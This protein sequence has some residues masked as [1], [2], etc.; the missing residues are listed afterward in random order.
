MTGHPTGQSGWLPARRRLRTSVAGISAA[1]LLLSLAPAADPPGRAATG[2]VIPIRGVIDDIMRDSIQRRV[3]E[4]QAAGATTLIFEID[5]P[6]GMVTSALDICRMIKNLPASV[7]TVAWVH[8]EAYSAGA[9]IAVACHQMWMSPSSS[10]GDCA[11]IM[12]VPVGGVQELGQTE[13]AKAES[14]ILQQFRDSAARN[15]YDQLLSRAMVT[16]GEEVWWLE[17]MSDPADRRFVT[18]EE[19][20]K[21]IDDV[22]EDAREWKLVESY[23][24]PVSGKSIPVVQ[25]VDRANE[26]LTMS[27]YDAVAFGF[28]RGVVADLGELSEKLGLGSIPITFEKSG[29]EKFAMWL[30]SPIVR[31]ILLVIVLIGGYVEFQHPGVI[32]PGVTALIALAIF[33]GAPYA[34]GLAD[35]WTIVI[36]V[37][38]LIL[39]GIEVFVTPGF[40]ILG[41]LGIALI[42]VAIIGSFVP[43]EP[44]APPFSLPSLQATW[45]GLVTG[46]KVLIG[47][48]VVSLVGVVLLAR[49]LPESRMATG[50]V[51]ANP[52]ADSL[53]LSEPHPEVAQVG[54]VGVVTG[55]LRPGGQARFGQEI[56]DVHSQG[57]YVEAGRRVQVIRRM[58]MHIEVRPLPEEGQ[59]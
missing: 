32:L 42:L 52:Q 4:A 59:A 48:V 13:R 55:D 11:P 58:G 51:S 46:L 7:Q 30:N 1:L 8:P 20:K 47:S 2:A 17:R 9:M 37:V 56:V 57:E 49:Y 19:K 15:G 29:W 31:G 38:G 35:I 33:L 34:A 28:A 39:L 6:G 41:L 40:G 18:G 24:E 26:L 50:V 36:L 25:P 22:A 44:G 43:A 53:A 54:D 45:N 21:L 27:Q 16:M 12:V 3:K 14:P 10:I 5:T 23:L